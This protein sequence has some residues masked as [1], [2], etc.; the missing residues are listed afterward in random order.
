VK[1][2]GCKWIFRTKNDSKGNVKRYKARLVTKRFTQKEDIDFT[3]TFSPVST[4]DS[5]RIIMAL[6]AYFD[7]ELHQ[8][9]V[10]T[11]F[12]NYDIDEYIICRNHRITSL[13]TRNR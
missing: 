9:D 12:L 13:M 8:M 5:F 10:K 7:L 6:V 4:K 1:S 3:E 11:V 2:I